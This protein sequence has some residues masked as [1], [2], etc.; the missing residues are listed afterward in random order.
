MKTDP[1][2]HRK[3]SLIA[4]PGACDLTEKLGRELGVATEKL[5]YRRFPDGE[6]HLR[7]PSASVANEVA[8][9]A[10]LD[11]PDARIPAVLFAAALARDL[12]AA[13]VGLIA[14][15]LPY[16]RQDIRFSPG[17]ALTSVTF[18]RWISNHFDW[19][20]T[21]DPHLHRY[22]SLDEIYSIA[23]AVVPAAPALAE[24]IT[25]NVE[26]AVVI[27]PD[28]ESTQWVAA[29]AAHCKLP[30]RV[31]TKERFGDHEVRI[32]APDLS[33]LAGH[34]PVLVDDIISS[35]ATLADSARALRQAGMPAPVCA[36]VH[37]LF[38]EQSRQTL[39]RAGIKRIVCSD[40]TRV[41]EAE[42]ELAPLLA[43]AV[44]G[45][46]SAACLID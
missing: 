9:V 3:L 43:P 36:I 2:S 16:M 44:A 31:M 20:V 27:G 37:G 41:A 14:P 38:G 19:L 24:W 8:L 33:G 26:Q 46:V 13:R 34:V 1:S 15:Y 40:S 7:L 11:R 25:A 18:A 12:G 29:V 4:L 39:A 35:G 17:E 45:L 22:H 30:W 6:S 32:D 10:R 5:E 28:M 23:S 21:V 42:I